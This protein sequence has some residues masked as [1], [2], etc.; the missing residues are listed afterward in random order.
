MENLWFGEKRNT[1]FFFHLIHL[2]KIILYHKISLYTVL[3][4]SLL[5]SHKFSRILFCKM[6]GFSFF[7]AKLLEINNFID[8]YILSGV[9][10]VLVSVLILALASYSTYIND[11]VVS[12]TGFLKL[13]SLE[14]FFLNYFIRINYL[15]LEW[16]L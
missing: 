1:F 7:K 13:F 14:F 10:C 8:S 16:M 2:I 4:I 12:F 9:S 3:S 15:S 6:F 5:V 11:Q